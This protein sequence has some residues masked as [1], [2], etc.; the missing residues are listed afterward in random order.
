MEVLLDKGEL[1]EGLKRLNN[2]CDIHVGL[3]IPKGLKATANYNQ[4]SFDFSY[5]GQT[6]TG[7][8]SID[9]LGIYLSITRFSGELTVKSLVVREYSLSAAILKI[10]RLPLA[11]M[12]PEIQVIYLALKMASR[13][14]GDKISE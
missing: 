14:F 4:M 9:A 7:T 3:A 12:Q 2:G 6:H 11:H 1:L 5:P 13:F 8:G 10:E